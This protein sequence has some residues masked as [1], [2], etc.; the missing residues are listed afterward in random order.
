MKAYWGSRGIA[1]RILGLG[2]RWKWV[3][4]F[5]HR[6]LYPRGNSPWYPLGRR[7]GA[8]QNRSGHGVEEKNSQPLPGLEPPIVLPV[9]QCYTT[10]ISYLCEEEVVT[11]FKNLAPYSTD[12]NHFSQFSLCY[13][14][15][16]RLT[17]W[18]KIQLAVSLITALW[19]RVV[20]VGVKLQTLLTL[21]L[22][23]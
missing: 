19:R 2:T 10:E 3:V 12:W 15:L 5:I 13:W 9:D 7:L 21:A 17:G 18:N 1:P 11:Y 6:P 16:C 8:L 23:G 22:N 14:T 20:C 4:S